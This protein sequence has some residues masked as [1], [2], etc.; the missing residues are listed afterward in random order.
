MFTRPPKWTNALLTC[1]SRAIQVLHPA[2]VVLLD[3]SFVLSEHA[4]LLA[5]VLLDRGFADTTHIQRFVAETDLPK[6]T[7]LAEK[8]AVG[9][10]KMAFLL[11]TAD[12][13]P[14]R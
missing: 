6:K 7:I 11:D 3:L 2:S 1:L 8:I 9:S 4:D 5:S 13:F 12:A 14:F 10:K